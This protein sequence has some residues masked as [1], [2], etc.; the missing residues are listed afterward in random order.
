MRDLK[1]SYLVHIGLALAGNAVCVL[2]VV[3]TVFPYSVSASWDG[4]PW[5]LGGIVVLAGVVLTAMARVWLVKATTGVSPV[6]KSLQVGA[7]LCLPRPF[8]VYVAVT[9][10]LLVAA[11]LWAMSGESVQ[12]G[13]ERDGVYFSKERAA[14]KPRWTE[15]DRETHDKLV[16]N[17]VRGALGVPGLFFTAAAV[18]VA[19]TAQADPQGRGRTA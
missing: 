1:V 2:G 17:D 14:G 6:D 3:W 7:W 15:V 12:S 4:G 10:A 11:A 16:R 19:V 5:A 18:I 8:Q 9:G 13:G